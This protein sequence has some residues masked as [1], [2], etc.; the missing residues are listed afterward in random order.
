MLFKT[1]SYIR[2]GLPEYCPTLHSKTGMVDTSTNCDSMFFEY[3]GVHSHIQL[4]GIKT[5]CQTQPCTLYSACGI[6]HSRWFSI[7]FKT[8]MGDI[9]GVVAYFSF[10]K[11]IV[12]NLI[13]DSA[14]F[15]VAGTALTMANYSCFEKNCVTSSEIDLIWFLDFPHK[16]SNSI[17]LNSLATIYTHKPNQHEA[18]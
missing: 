7:S 10:S 5:M 18:F 17:L 2:H 14:I 9:C 1:R 12:A 16:F 3:L 15:L 13:H 6:L 8:N 4:K 11:Q